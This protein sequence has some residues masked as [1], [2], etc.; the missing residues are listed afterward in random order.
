MCHNC[1]PTEFNGS[2]YPVF[3]NTDQKSLIEYKTGYWAV[4]YPEHIVHRTT[5]LIVGRYETRADAEFAI[6]R[7]GHSVKELK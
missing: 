2:P 6:T 4:F 1:K 3:I 5:H 7:L